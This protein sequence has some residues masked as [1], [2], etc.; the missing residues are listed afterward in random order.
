VETALTEKRD[1][2]TLR[3]GNCNA[4]LLAIAAGAVFVA[5][6]FHDFARAQALDDLLQKSRCT[7]AVYFPVET[8]NVGRM[9]KEKNLIKVQVNNLETPAARDAFLT[10]TTAQKNA[11]FPKMEPVHEFITRGGQPFG[12]AAS[13]S[14]K[15]LEQ[16]GKMFFF[17]YRGAGEELK[18]LR[19]SYRSIPPHGQL[20]IQEIG[21]LDYFGR[22]MKTGVLPALN[23]CR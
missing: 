11:Q 8:V 16:S 2:D 20:V 9:F 21:L 19:V 1:P 14:Y 23:H 4:R 7:Q 18:K 17:K 13:D 15:G 5:A 6:V 10:G 3:T 12:A 22:M